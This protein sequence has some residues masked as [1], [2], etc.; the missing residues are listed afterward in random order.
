[1]SQKKTF[2]PAVVPYSVHNH[3]LSAYVIMKILSIYYY[4]QECEILFMNPENCISQFADVQ[5]PD[6]N[7][8]RPKSEDHA[9][10][11]LIHSPKTCQVCGFDEEYWNDEIQLRDR[12]IKELRDEIDT[13]RQLIARN[14][15]S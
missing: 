14:G 10:T 9:T 7:V 12:T 4:H 13:L 1:M 11:S 5:R 3:G 6:S 8:T 2:S 15:K